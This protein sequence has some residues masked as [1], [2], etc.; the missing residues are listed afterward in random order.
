MGIQNGKKYMEAITY[1]GNGGTQSVGGLSFSPDLVWIKSRNNSYDHHLIDTV[2]GNESS[3]SSNLNYAEQF[4]YSG[5][6]SFDPDGF[7]LGTNGE[8]NE[9]TSTFVAWCF[10]AGNETVTNNEGT[11]ESQVRS[12]GNFSV[13]KYTGNYTNGD[14]FG[15]GLTNA[16]AFAIIKST[17][18]SR[19]WA[20]YHSSLSLTDNLYLNT[21]DSAAANGFWTTVAPTSD[22]MSLQNT[23]YINEL[24]EEYIAY[25]W[26]DSPT[27]KF[28][29]YTG[30]GNATG[31]FVY[32][33]FKPNFVMVKGIDSTS[34]WTIVDAE[35]GTSKLLYAD[36]SAIEDTNSLR[37]SG[38]LSNGFTIG[39]SSDVNTNNQQYIY[40]AFAD[41]SFI[42]EPQS[43]EVTLSGTAD[44]E[45]LAIGNTVTQPSTGESGV[46]TSKDENT[47]KI[48][49][50][51]A[52]SMDTGAPLTSVL[53]GSGEVVSYDVATNSMI[54]T[55]V[56]GGFAVGA[57]KTVEGSI[58]RLPKYQ[59]ET[60]V[61][62]GVE[63]AD[64][65][66]TM[67]NSLS[68]NDTTGTHF[69][70]RTPS[71]D[72]NRRTWTWSGW[73]KKTEYGINQYV[74]G[75][76]TTS[77]ASIL[78]SG[79]SL[80]FSDG[81]TTPSTFIGVSE[82][83]DPSEW[84]HLVVAFDTT[85]STASDRVKIYINGVHPALTQAEYPNQ[86]EEGQFG[87]AIEH[88]I[89][90]YYEPVNGG[91]QGDGYSG[92]LADVQF[93]NGQSLSANAFGEFDPFGR[94]IA[95]GYTGEH[96]TNGFALNF[97]NPL[98]LGEDSSGGGNDFTP[99]NLVG[100]FTYSDEETSVI[101][102]IGITQTDGS[103]QVISGWPI[104]PVT[105]NMDANDV[106]YLGDRFIYTGNEGAD[107]TSG[108][109]SY[110]LDGLTWIKGQGVG[111]N[112][113]MFGSAWN[114]S[115]IVAVGTQSKIIYSDDGGVNWSVITG[116]S[117]YQYQEIAYGGGYF[118]ATTE[119]GRYS[120]STD[121]INWTHASESFGGNGVRAMAY[122]DGKFVALS[123][124]TNSR[125]WYTS[126][127][128]T[129]WTQG[130][131]Y[132]GGSTWYK[133]VY[134]NGTF[135]ASGSGVMY[136]TDGSDFSGGS[137]NLSSS[138]S[139]ALAFGNDIFVTYSNDGSGTQAWSADGQTWTNIINGDAIGG[140]SPRIAAAA[141]GSGKF[142]VLGTTKGSYS[143]TGSGLSI[144]R[145]VLTLTDNTDLSGFL[146][147]Q[148]VTQ[149]SV[150][151]PETSA[152]TG[153]NATVGIIKQVPVGT[154]GDWE[155]I[156]GVDA[157]GGSTSGPVAVFDDG[158]GL[159][160]P[161]GYITYTNMTIG[162]TITLYATAGG[163]TSRA[164]YGDV[165]ETSV[166]DPG[167]IMTTITLTTT[168]TSG[169]FKIDWNV[170]ANVYGITPGPGGTTLNLTDDTNLANFRVGDAVQGGGVLDTT[171]TATAWQGSQSDTTV[172]QV[173]SIGGNMNSNYSGNYAWSTI[174]FS[175]PL[176]G[177]EFKFYVEAGCTV[178]NDSN[179]QVAT[180][181]S[182]G[183][184]VV[185]DD[186]TGLL[187]SVSFSVTNG[188]G[189]VTGPYVD[190]V[191]TTNAVKVDTLTATASYPIPVYASVTAINEV[192]PSIT[193]DGG[194]WNTGETISTTTTLPT[195]KVASVDTVLNTMTLTGAT[196]TWMVTESGYETAKKLNKFV[197]TSHDYTADSDNLLDVPTPYGTDTG[198]GGEMRGNYATLNPLDNTN[199]MVLSEGN[200]KVV[201]VSGAA[202]LVK[203]SIAFNSGKW[204]AEYT[205][206]ITDQTNQFGIAEVSASSATYIGASG[207]LGYGWEPY[208]DRFYRNGNNSNGDFGVTYTSGTYVFGLAVDMDNN[209][210]DFYVDGSLV[211]QESGITPGNYMFAWADAYSSGTGGA[212]VNF[213][214][215][216]FVHPGPD[217]YL[218]LN[219]SNL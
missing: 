118:V 108:D 49:L 121:G 146:I 46:I 184:L 77:Q 120:Y 1:T 161:N 153:V 63:D 128:T 19:D 124:N 38:L 119:D 106:N 73:L 25:C 123:N 133:M 155:G 132:G 103:Y 81:T 164:I 198:R 154:T 160:S 113:S 140:G 174:V 206:T 142:I 150:G 17:T 32:T 117:G 217:G 214:Q 151:T 12:N 177:S 131:Y 93:I 68:F 6:M 105:T 50:T 194:T 4:T 147:G 115:R 84:F 210:I 54:V 40:A 43:T 191:L 89:G 139:G 180:A 145:T 134:G 136:S 64:P 200:L 190:G 219:T 96:G 34:P 169:S 175:P 144:D 28:G 152:I 199:S 159:A 71:T 187:S 23:P 70:D 207:Q 97:S 39:A 112:N 18:L 201:G 148:P 167:A 61:L 212:T 157:S 94:W 138:N 203:S 58:R 186:G 88:I 53:D 114:G 100:N 165:S 72:G 176:Q 143:L 27:Q 216:P 31:I 209:T 116:G 42:P 82:S 74:M 130:S 91:V 90:S 11:I 172:A 135:V 10:D 20:V 15:H 185:P 208:V 56:V 86:N 181:S 163:T 149:D 127:I 193:T 30:N 52:V 202:G 195:G 110:S 80:Y 183:N 78:F 41:E 171:V 107:G 3:L 192:T 16:P 122:G 179:N 51:G 98:S 173:I 156:L 204:Y 205:C 29:S 8:Y 109:V 178:R 141:Y 55:N 5:V 79:G 196:G 37:V 104:G 67:A 13:V 87:S 14:T 101:T 75:V 76:G 168:S 166:S 62:T 36:S 7:T 69:L 162:Q 22:V 2:R 47:N 9:V 24:D 92:Y 48:T 189:G 35:R 59:S 215:R 102:D 125:S 182:T 218:T 188:Q 83:N 45:N 66:Y 60:A 197:V 211:G 137:G 65:D 213:G 21:T 158:G 33:G 111:S 44:F 99:N 95:K 126:D 85:H 26:A 170:G 129:G 57:G